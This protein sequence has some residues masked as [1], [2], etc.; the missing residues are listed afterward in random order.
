ME[1]K[2]FRIINRAGSIK[3]GRFTGEGSIIDYNNK[4]VYDG[5][6]DRGLLSGSGNYIEWIT[7]P[8]KLM[9]VSGEFKQ[10]KLVSGAYYI[11]DSNFYIQEDIKEIRYVNATKTYQGENT[12]VTLLSEWEGL[13]PM[14]VHEIEFIDLP[15]SSYI[16]YN[17]EWIADLPKDKF[18]AK[19][20]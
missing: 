5:K 17:Y 12:S 7:A 13:I 19:F 18:L 16:K 2:S 10:G 8:E 11:S 1:N 15:N 14:N 3:N 6:F 4:I 20:G 9:Y